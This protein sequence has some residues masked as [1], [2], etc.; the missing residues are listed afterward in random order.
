MAS[1]LSQS[2]FREDVVM[3]PM[4][5]IDVLGI[6]VTPASIC[7][8]V[9]L[10]LSLGLRRLLDSTGIDRFVWNRALVDLSILIATTSLL[11]LS[12]RFEGR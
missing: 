5:E 12:L 4:R 1:G 2:L 10:P 11:V 8:L 3:I 6:F 9:A 7:L